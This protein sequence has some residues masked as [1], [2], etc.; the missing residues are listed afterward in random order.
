[1]SEFNNWRG[2]FPQIDDLLIIGLR[3]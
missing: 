2:D 3:I 1:M